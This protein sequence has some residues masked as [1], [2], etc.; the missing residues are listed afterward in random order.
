METPALQSF[1]SFIRPFMVAQRKTSPKCCT[2]RNLHELQQEAVLRV[3]PKMRTNREVDVQGK[4]DNKEWLS[5]PHRAFLS[6]DRSPAAS[7]HMLMWNICSI[8]S[9]IYMCPCIHASRILPFRNSLYQCCPS[10]SRVSFP[11][12]HFRTLPW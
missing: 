2:V 10:E 11:I 6:T 12:I 4:K 1:L 7:Q 5:V 9:S 3:P 8:A